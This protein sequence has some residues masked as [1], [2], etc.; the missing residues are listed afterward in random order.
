[1]VPLSIRGMTGWVNPSF[2]ALRR[3][4][5][6]SVARRRSVGAFFCGKPGS[7]ALW[8]LRHVGGGSRWKDAARAAPLWHTLNKTD[9]T[10]WLQELWVR[11]AQ[12]TPR[13]STPWKISWWCRRDRLRRIGR[14][15]ASEE[16][17]THDPRASMRGC[18]WKGGAMREARRQASA[19][20]VVESA[21]ALADVLPGTRR[22]VARDIGSLSVHP[23]PSKPSAPGGVAVAMGPPAGA[24][25]LRWAL[26]AQDGHGRGAPPRWLD[27]RRRMPS[28]HAAVSRPSDG[29]SRHAI[30]RRRH[31]SMELQTRSLA[32]SSA[33]EAA[34]AVLRSPWLPLALQVLLDEGAVLPGCLVEERP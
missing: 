16:S 31:P 8:G 9:R 14:G 2:L 34:I 15:T 7:F 19:Q 29:A 3:P 18:A 30:C 5:T 28:V 4:W 22:V 13:P 27:A 26:L 10:P 17:A 32:A 11:R 1:M 21:S 24:A 23:D 33:L 25:R 20:S 6:F 12:C